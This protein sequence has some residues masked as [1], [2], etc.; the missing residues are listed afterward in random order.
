MKSSS[1][2][3]NSAFA[4]ILTA[5]T[6]SLCCITPLIAILAGSGGIATM[7]SWLEPFRPYLIGLTIGILVFAWYLKLKPRTQKE[8]EC[9]CDEDEKTSFWRSKSFLFVITVFTALMLTFPYYSRLFYNTSEKEILVVAENNIEKKIIEI[10][11]MTCAGCEA[12][13]EN[14][15]NKLPGIISVKASYENSNAIVEFD[16]SKVT[17]T[18]IFMAINK[19][20]YKAI[21]AEKKIR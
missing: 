15:V 1:K 12:H 10:E 11:G 9:A 2:S 8:I 20:G 18:E 7:F 21:T 19:T 14:E 3:T 4:S 5:I 13:V 17:A 16:K 6:A